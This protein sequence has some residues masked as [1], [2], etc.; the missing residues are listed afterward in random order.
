MEQNG[1]QGFFVRRSGWVVPPLFAVDVE[2]VESRVS[3]MSKERLVEEYSALKTKAERIERIGPSR[4]LVRSEDIYRAARTGLVAP[5][6]F[7]PYRRCARSLAIDLMTVAE[8]GGVEVSADDLRSFV[9]G[10]LVHSLYYEK[11]AEGE[12]E[13]PVESR[14]LGIV[15]V[16]D[17]LREEEG[18]KVVIEVKSSWRPDIVG[19][20]LQVMSYMLAVSESGS[21]KVGGFIVTPGGCFKVYLDRTVL[22]EY[23]RRLRKVVEVALS[24]DR[25]S[26]PP[27]LPRELEHRCEACH[28][29]WKCLSLP[30]EYRSYRRYFTAMGFTK[31]REEKRRTL[32][33]FA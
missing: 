25:R 4:Y 13:V 22:D 12:T 8:L 32:E 18:W 29:R 7:I 1:K 21:N 2:K 28:N 5:S 14:E 11:Y 27:R 10:I 26:L 17:E 31:I 16:I 20:G 23:I 19:A 6:M 33:G 30:D 15:G 3:S 9:K 24:G